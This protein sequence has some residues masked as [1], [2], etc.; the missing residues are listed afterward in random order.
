MGYSCFVSHCSCKLVYCCARAREALAAFGKLHSFFQYDQ[1]VA[2]CAGLQK[3]SKQLSGVSKGIAA[4]TSDLAHGGLVRRLNGNGPS[5]D[6]ARRTP[7]S[8]WLAQPF[9]KVSPGHLIRQ[10]LPAV[11]FQWQ[12]GALKAQ[13]CTCSWALLGVCPFLGR[14]SRRL[15]STG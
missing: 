9:L 10:T 15:H 8:P 2:L 7:Y 14:L 5:R 1:C 4:L 11:V 6:S 3:A 12:S 13:G